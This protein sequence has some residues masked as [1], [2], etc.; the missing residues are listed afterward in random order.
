MLIACSEATVPP[1]PKSVAFATHVANIVAD[2]A[3]A[4]A[5]TVT[6][7]D[8][9]PGPQSLIA[10]SSSAP[11][12]ATVDSKGLVTAVA[13]GTS[14]I[15]AQTGSLHD[16]LTVTVSW[17]PIIT[18]TFGRDT[19][20]LLLD[21]SLSTS[22]IATNSHAKPAPNAVVTYTSSSTS[23]ATVD[24]NGRIRTFAIGASTITAT[25][26]NLHSDILVT[27][28][29]HFT[30]IATGAEHT[31]QQAEAE[32]WACQGDAHHERSQKLVHRTS[33]PICR[34]HRGR[35][36]ADFRQRAMPPH[37]EFVSVVCETDARLRR[38][39]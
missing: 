23:V 36:L 30:Q 26:E 1:T 21:D 17:A 39:R 14:T 6:M 12:V 35:R 24:A 10:Y 2:D 32:A 9:S 4:L 37:A 33:S 18:I 16:E 19:A 31:V 20:T 25:E 13:A 27:V 15:S 34:N 29:P 3:L 11:A 5:A 28:V 8:G 22:I 7:S 38:F